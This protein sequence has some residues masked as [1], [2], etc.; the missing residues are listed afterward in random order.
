MRVEEIN[1]T[2]ITITEGGRG[3][4]ASSNDESGVVDTGVSVAEIDCCCWH[5]RAAD[6]NGFQPRLEIPIACNQYRD[7]ANMR[8]RES[9]DSRIPRAIVGCNRV[10]VFYIAPDGTLIAVE[11]VANGSKIEIGRVQPLFGGLPA[12]NTGAIP[13]DVAPDGKRFLVAVQIAP[14]ESEALVVVQ[15]WRSALQ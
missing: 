1:L 12:N 9:G 13:Y 3:M 7:Q 10:G 6:Q 4:R 8:C 15:N 2:P 5:L 11:I 14:A